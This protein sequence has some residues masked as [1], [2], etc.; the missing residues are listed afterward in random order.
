MQV[1]CYNPR[2]KQRTR[3]LIRKLGQAP[4]G[5]WVVVLTLPAL[6]PLARPGFFAADDGIFHIY[7]LDALDRAVR[8]GVLYPRW[9]PELAFGYGH[10]V[11]N[12]YG[13]LSYYW[14]LPLTLLGADAALALQLVFAT[15]LVASALALYLFARLH[16]D[17]GPALV[18]AVVYAYL[19]YHLVDLY[20]RGAVAE[21]LAFVWFPL[22]LWAFHR[23]VAGR[24]RPQALP[25]RL[26]LAAL[27]EAALV[28]THSLSALLFA[29]VLCAYMVILL[30]REWDLRALG[31]VT[32]ALVLAAAVSAFYWLPVMAESRFVGLGFGASQGYRDHLL[33]W[34][35]LFDLGLTYP[36]STEPGV[37]RV[38]PLGMVQVLIVCV[39][40][41]AAFRPG[42]RRWVCL[43][44]LAVAIVSAFML[45]AA[46]LPLWRLFER[47]LAF[48]QYPWRF[49]SL[50]A[51]ASAFLAGAVVQ[52]VTRS[53]SWG[54]AV[55]GAAILATTWVWAVGRLSIV[56]ATPDISVE[57]MWQMDREYGQV[58]TT[59]TG[60]YLPIWVTEQRWALSHAQP[61]PDPGEA[62]LPP[63]QVR[64]AG[65]GHT[66]YDIVLNTSLGAKVILHQFFYP[67]WQ[68]AEQGS[69]W[70]LSGHP[71]GVLGLASFTLPAK[72]GSFSLHLGY[73]PPQ[74]W[75]TVLS[76]LTALVVA[77]SLAAPWPSSSERS[78][79]GS[80]SLIASFLLLATILLA[81]LVRPNGAVR[82][83]LPVNAN[84]EGK[85]ELLAYTSDGTRYRPGD[86]VDV[87]IYWRALNE[88][89][90]EYK[91]FVHMTD[92]AVT[93]Q[94]VQHDGDPGGGF[95]P[96]TRWLP[97]ELVPD[98]HHLALPV[99]LA[100]GRYLLWAGMYEYPTLRNLEIVASEAPTT[101]S[102]TAVGR[103]LLGEI[104]VIAP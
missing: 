36:Y 92:K 48:L 34:R 28:V 67:G 7:R 104:E 52:R 62:H 1:T 26:G 101:G 50:T 79:P 8:A 65:V 100:P 35:N 103:V 11:L 42:P 53:G 72:S 97:G 95:S 16:L 54:R 74:R 25:Y 78:R 80:L 9:F 98:T 70:S 64:L 96:T 32:A 46:S 30:A 27:L 4:T 61:G 23:L 45:S 91:A 38:F 37:A 31:R 33:A 24:G 6:A 99:D 29:P 17:R 55:L 75:G 43:F 2:V 93:S 5:W 21:F 49:L 18:A 19:P 13:P 69:R 59:W 68:A 86:V 58:G 85:V 63:G 41:F 73:T 77:G 14:G 89:E 15:G 82:A 81:S 66:R 56:P 84:L 20:V 44:F 76:L 88:L 94:P 12:F 90:Q 87:T 39:A 71:E 60:E 47:G 10:P 51:F 57:A 102:R 3:A 83:A 22:V 40:A